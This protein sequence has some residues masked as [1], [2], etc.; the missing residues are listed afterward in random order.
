MQDEAISQLGY[1]HL[2]PHPGA[3]EDHLKGVTC[4]WCET[5]FFRN[6]IVRHFEHIFRDLESAER[7]KLLLDII[8]DDM[9]YWMKQF[10]TA[11]SDVAKFLVVREVVLMT[12]QI[13]YEAGK[14][15]L[16]NCKDY[17]DDRHKRS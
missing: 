12:L 7:K 6:D 8:D 10:E 16:V 5:T 15:V 13:R 2:K 17:V 11:T 4:I 3:V 14:P 9:Q 1:A